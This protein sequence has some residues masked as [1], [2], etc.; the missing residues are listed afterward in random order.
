V[1]AI[2]E[3]MRHLPPGKGRNLGTS[4]A[5]PGDGEFDWTPGG[6]DSFDDETEVRGGALP[7]AELSRD[8]AGF[9]FGRGRE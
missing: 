7:S 3:S 8:G 9:T 1:Y 2:R 6:L 4:P 5:S